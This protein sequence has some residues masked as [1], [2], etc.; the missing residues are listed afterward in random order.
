MTMHLVR[1]MSSTN[2]GKRKQTGLT[3]RD[4]QAQVEHDAWLR[5]QGLHPTQLKAKL[6]HDAKGRRQ[7]VCSMPDY[8]E[9]VNTLP[10][11]DTITAVEGKRKENRYTGDEL[12]GIGVMHKSN[13][14]PIRK[15]SKAAEEIAR[16]RR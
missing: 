6:P 13:M 16:M 1:G 5:S 12:A 3:Q 14:V 2:T 10:T 8:S 11:S 7:G 4:R 15:D 9:R